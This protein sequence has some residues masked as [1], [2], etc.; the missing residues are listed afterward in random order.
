MTNTSE[1]SSARTH[2]A[3]TRSSVAQQQHIEDDKT[4]TSICN[5]ATR[6]MLFV[7]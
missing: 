1:V 2:S 6:F 7:Y 3:E 5:E 4:S